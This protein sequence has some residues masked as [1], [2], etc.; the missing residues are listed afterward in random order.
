MIEVGSMLRPK[1][2]FPSV[3]MVGLGKV[4]SSILLEYYS[5]QIDVLG[6]SLPILRIYREQS[7]E[8]VLKLSAPPTPPKVNA[9]GLLRF[10]L[11]YFLPDIL[12][13]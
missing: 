10:W 5:R 8:V 1:K 7:Q 3:I 9:T 11:A 6:I 13:Y 4:Q 2:Y 12:F